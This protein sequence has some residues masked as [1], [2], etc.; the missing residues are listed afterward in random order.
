[1]LIQDMK[2]GE[3]TRRQSSPYAVQWSREQLPVVWDGVDGLESRSA[4]VLR[5]AQRR[6]PAQRSLCH[7]IRAS[8]PI[9]THRSLSRL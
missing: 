7:R 3:G 8:A 4:D 9:Q 6:G 2:P 1:V 5:F